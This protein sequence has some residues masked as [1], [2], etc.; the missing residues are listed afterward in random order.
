MGCLYYLR[1]LDAIEMV[2]RVVRKRLQLFQL[3]HVP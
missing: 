2:T 1:Q 3:R